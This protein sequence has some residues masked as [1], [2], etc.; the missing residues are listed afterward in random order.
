[1]R[2]QV[3]IYKCSNGARTLLGLRNSEQRR[4]VSHKR[5][6]TLVHTTNDNMHDR[7]IRPEHKRHPSEWR[8]LG[9]N[10]NHNKNT[11]YTDSFH[12]RCLGYVQNLSVLLTRA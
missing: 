10:S 2:A 1:M 9:M 11:Q 3:N 6:L 7:A 4:P 5:L 12:P 8:V